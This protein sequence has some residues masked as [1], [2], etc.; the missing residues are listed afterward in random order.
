MSARRA[1]RCR[2]AT[3]PDK[4][5]PP[6]SSA[7]IDGPPKSLRKKVGEALIR[8]I[9]RGDTSRSLPGINI[10]AP[11]LAQEVIEAFASA[12]FEQRTHKPTRGGCMSK[13]LEG[14]KGA[15][16]AKG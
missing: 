10:R 13:N 5:T 1:R 4:G 9:H 7:S 8:G 6:P 14:G 3:R 2:C 15:K 16:G 11:R 12:A